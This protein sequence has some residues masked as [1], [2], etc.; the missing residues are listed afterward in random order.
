MADPVEWWL[1]PRVV[2]SVL[3][4]IVLLAV[5]STPRAELG[6]GLPSL[7]TFSHAENGARGLHDLAERLG[8]QVEQRLE[9]YRAPVDSAEIGRAHV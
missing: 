7:T 3:A 9:P 5:I 8:W 4:F 2:F 6:G 1:R